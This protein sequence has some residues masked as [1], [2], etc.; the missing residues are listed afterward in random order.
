MAQLVLKLFT[1]D[2]TP[3]SE[4]AITSLRRLCEEK[5]NGRCELILV[6]VLEQPQVAED[7]TVF[8]TPTLI[9]ASPPPAR[10]VVGALSDADRVLEG[11][12]LKEILKASGD[13]HL[14]G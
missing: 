11:L 7:E 5:L 13:R 14:E 6:D 8:V 3:R 1:T 9:R 10:R 2:R 12:G 4:Q